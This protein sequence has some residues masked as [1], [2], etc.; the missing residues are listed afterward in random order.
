MLTDAKKIEL[1]KRFTRE[2]YDTAAAAFGDNPSGANWG[3]LEKAMWAHQAISPGGVLHTNPQMLAIVNEK[4]I[5]H[6]TEEL[7]KGAKDGAV[8]GESG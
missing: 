3:R 7:Y 4:P 5:G 1:L 8:P 6:W 2:E